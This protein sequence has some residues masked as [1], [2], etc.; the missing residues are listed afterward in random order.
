MAVHVAGILYYRDTAVAGILN[1]AG[2]LKDYLLITM[3][4][5]FSVIVSKLR[6][7]PSRS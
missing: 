6:K 3:N 4:T 1:V 5:Y 7:A 2:I